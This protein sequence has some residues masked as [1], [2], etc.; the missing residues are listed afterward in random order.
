MN[1]TLNLN[2][3]SPSGSLASQFVA[4]GDVDLEAT[5]TISSSAV[6]AEQDI[7]VTATSGAAGC[8]AIML[9]ASA[10]MVVHGNS[11]AGG[12]LTGNDKNIV[13]LVANVPYFWIAGNGTSPI[14]A[15]WA[16]IYVDSTPGGTLQVRALLNN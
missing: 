4:T 7:V 2:Y 16:A 3:Q 11:V 1:H 5:Y 8:Q 12:W 15:S 6:K 13:T 14:T 10:A 9:L